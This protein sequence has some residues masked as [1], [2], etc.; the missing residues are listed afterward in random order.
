MTP[1]EIADQLKN[2]TSRLHIQ[3]CNA[4]RQGMRL[5]EAY[6]IRKYYSGRDYNADIGL[7]VQSGSAGLRAAWHISEKL[8][9]T[10]FTVVLANSKKYGLIHEKGG[11]IRAKNAP[12]LCFPIKTTSMR[13]KATKRGTHTR[14]T[15]TSWVRVKE[16]KI[17][18][19]T[20][21]EGDFVR[22]GKPMILEQMN[23]I[24]RKALNT[25]G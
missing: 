15:T 2:S 20:N 16:V 14:M 25:K 23:Q 6:I 5:Y 9:G 11:V 19:R 13:V 8:G 1:K 21:V 7:N 4:M 18:K 10:D 3:M 12:Y 22:I 17:P 24:I